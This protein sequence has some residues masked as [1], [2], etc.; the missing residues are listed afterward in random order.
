[1]KRSSCINWNYGKAKG[2]IGCTLKMTCEQPCG[3]Y[4]MRSAAKK[5]IKKI[6]MMKRKIVYY[7]IKLRREQ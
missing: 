6:E 3:S 4:Y 7:T 2:P 5:A 1:M